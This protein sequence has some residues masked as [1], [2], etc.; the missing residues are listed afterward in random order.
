[1]VRHGDERLVVGEARANGEALGSLNIEKMESQ[2][3]F[4]SNKIKE[5]DLLV[6]AYSAMREHKL[7]KNSGN[8]CN[9][10]PTNNQQ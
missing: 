2:K 7:P 4:E 8:D 6:I 1:M 10:T 3:V 5:P 9:K